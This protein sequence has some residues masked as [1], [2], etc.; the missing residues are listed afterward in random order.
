MADPTA[1]DGDFHVNA[2]STPI[3]VA[4]YPGA[5]AEDRVERR[6]PGR[7]VAAARHAVV[8]RRLWLETG[9]GYT[10]PAATLDGPAWL[11]VARPRR[12]GPAGVRGRALLP[13]ADARR[14]AL[15]RAPPHGRLPGRGPAPRV[16][17]VRARAIRDAQTNELWSAAGRR[18]A[19][20][21]RV[22]AGGDRGRERRDAGARGRGR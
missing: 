20:R 7:C 11:E 16:R 17:A 1:T 13:R 8:G 21:L 2:S 4:P 22:R 9:A 19:L 14:P 5:G 12:A 6:M 18:R 10:G 15:R 3:D